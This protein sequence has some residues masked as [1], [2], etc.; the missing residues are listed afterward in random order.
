MTSSFQLVQHRECERGDGQETGAER[1][2]RR[3]DSR[4]RRVEQQRAGARDVSSEDGEAPGG[5]GKNCGVSLREGVPNEFVEAD[6][7][8]PRQEECGSVQEGEKGPACRIRLD[9]VG[10]QDGITRSQWSRCGVIPD[11]ADTVRRTTDATDGL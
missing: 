10:A 9:D 1:P 2:W 8:I 11:D 7:S 3:L 6:A 5:N 4:N